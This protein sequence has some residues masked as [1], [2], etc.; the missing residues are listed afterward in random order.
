VSQP[1]HAVTELL[2]RWCSGSKEALE[3]LIPLLYQE[4]H[5]VARRQMRNERSAD[6]LQ[7][8]ALVHEVY[9]RLVGQAPGSIENRQHFVGIA[10]R[11]MRQI[12]VD[13]AREKRAAKRDGGVRVELDESLLGSSKLDIDVIA[14]DAALTEL[15]KLDPRQCQI[16]EL[17]FFGGLSVEDTAAFIGVSEATVKREWSTARV[18]LTRE[19]AGNP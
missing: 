4:L 3:Q 15:A 11:L 10:S 19:L 14:L 16:V 8:T 12:L 9:L 17:R 5:R 6:T 18:W 13:H 1:T 2:N 7:S